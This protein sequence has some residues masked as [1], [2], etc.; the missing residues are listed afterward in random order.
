MGAGPATGRDLEARRLGRESGKER[1]DEEVFSR[2]VHRGDGL[3][4]AQQR[5]RGW[6]GHDLQCL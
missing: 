6:Q 2:G 5:Y 1:A 3:V 4:C